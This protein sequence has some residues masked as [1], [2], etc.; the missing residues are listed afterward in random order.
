MALS[1]EAIRW[2]VA[3]EQAKYRIF[4]A[5]PEEL[6]VDTLRRV[7][8][9]DGRQGFRIAGQLHRIIMRAE[10]E[11]VLG[12]DQMQFLRRMK[13]RPRILQIRI[14]DGEEAGNQGNDIHQHGDDE[15]HHG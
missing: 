11:P 3:I 1:G 5:A 4:V 13:G 15:R 8:L 14:V 9:E 6:H 2:D 10:G 12:I 7:F